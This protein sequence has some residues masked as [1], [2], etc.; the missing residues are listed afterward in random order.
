MIHSMTH[1]MSRA[2]LLLLVATP[3]MAADFWLARG[4]NSI[5]SCALINGRTYQ[6]S[7]GFQTKYTSRLPNEEAVRTAM[8]FAASAPV[9]RVPGEPMAQDVHDYMILPCVEEPCLLTHYL[10]QR[11]S[12]TVYVDL[13]RGPEAAALLELIQLNC[14]NFI[15]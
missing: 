5:G 6:N 13:R 7:A 2:I 4:S 9:D 1:S 15:P 8:F 12:D 14:R 3:A 11:W 10:R